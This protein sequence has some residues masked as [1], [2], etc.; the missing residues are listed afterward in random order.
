MFIREQNIA[1][2][3]A[4][5]YLKGGGEGGAREDPKANGLYVYLG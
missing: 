4:G 5:P 2:L 1:D 3:F